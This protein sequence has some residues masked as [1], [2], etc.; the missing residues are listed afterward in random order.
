MADYVTYVTSINCFQRERKMTNFKNLIAAAAIGTLALGL[1]AC[2]KN[3]PVAEKGP[4]EKAGAQLDQAASKAAVEL[5]KVAEE[6]GKGLKKAGENLQG[7]AKDAQ[8]K[9]DQAKNEQPPQK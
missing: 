3:E 7:A 8:A 6:A 4:A 1:S 5:N 9:N 2:Q